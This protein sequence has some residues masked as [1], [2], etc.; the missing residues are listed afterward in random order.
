MLVK[1]DTGGDIIPP[2]FSGNNTYAFNDSD[3]AN[4]LNDYFVSI[5]NINDCETELPPFIYKTDSR[6]DNISFTQTEII[7]VLKGLNVNKACGPD[8]ISHRMLKETSRTISLPLT[9]LF[10]R[11]L[12]EQT[13]P[14]AWKIANV[15]PPF[16]KG[17][18]ESPSNYRPISLISC[19]GKVMERIVFKHIYNYMHSTNL[20]YKN[21]SGFLPGHSTVY[22]L[23][24]IYNQ[25]CK[26]FDDKQSTCMVFCDVSKAFDRVWHRGLLFKLRQY[27]I[28]GNAIKWLAAYLEG[29]QQRV[30]LN[31]SS[32]ELKHLNAGVPQGSV[33]GP[34]LFLIYVNDISD[35]LLSTVRL[36]ADDSSLSVSSNDV[37]S[38]ETLLN[39]DLQKMTNWAKQWLVTFNPNKTEVVFFSLVNRIKPTLIIDDTVLEYVNS[40]KHLGITFSNDGTWHEHISNMIN[41]ASK[42][43]NSMRMVKYK[44]NRK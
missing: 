22:Q 25:I 36:F 7:D 1:G 44:L 8:Q 9:M 16:K 37:L 5:S 6:L 10:S 17:E 20:I 2:L 38:I 12:R 11:S 23:I 27:G 21:Q 28:T 30:I 32:S 29:R 3:K 31:S 35:S 26:A 15:M 13:F 18:K 4:I 34:L 14:N 24:D 43:L 40:H 39:S 41:S 33:L 42:I 19:L